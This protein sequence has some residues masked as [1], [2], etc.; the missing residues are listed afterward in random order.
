MAV[1]V[2]GTGRYIY[3]D[4]LKWPEGERWEL[5]EGVAY[6]MSP[7]PS[8]RHQDV[9]R[10]LLG[11]LYNQFREHARKLYPAPFDVR[12]PDA[13]EPDGEVETVVQPDLV[14]VCDPRKLDDAG[15]RGAPDLAI[16][17]LS[18]ATAYKDQTQKLRLY[19]RH[20]VRELWIVNPDARIVFVYRLGADGAYPKPEVYSSGETVRLSAVEGVSI[21][22][23]AVFGG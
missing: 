16:E 10:E 12:L 23:A 7:T 6:A 18:P 4:Y 8:R 13:A 11:Q 21:D 15:C 9:L 22:L 1:P 2:P 3:A 19:E 14:V 17:I 5:I 20:G